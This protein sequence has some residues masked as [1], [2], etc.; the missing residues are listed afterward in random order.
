[1]ETKK[2]YT[3]PVIEIIMLD[4]EISLALESL[5]PEGPDE[6]PGY[7]QNCPLKEGVGLV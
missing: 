2:K 5:P 4:N 1:M 7:S 6:A 3:E